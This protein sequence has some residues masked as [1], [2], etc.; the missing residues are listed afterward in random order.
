MRSDARANKDKIV[1]A[2]RQVLEAGD[3][4]GMAAIAREAGVGQGTI[5]R[6]F[7]TWEDLVIE[8]HRADMDELSS[9]APDLLRQHP[10]MEALRRWLVMLADYG[11][12]KNALGDAMAT[13]LHNALG[14]TVQTPDL[15]ALRTLLEAAQS[16]GSVRQDVTAEDV[17]LL[18]GF[19]WRI[20]PAPDRSARTGRLLDAVLRG[21]QPGPS[22]PRRDRPH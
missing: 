14:R 18:V 17:F 16:E 4:S 20:E 12:L 2:A 11:R 10:P 1:A 9:A 13:A 8:V 7:P 15:S 3:A 22:M 21:L 19:L 6:H 5:Y